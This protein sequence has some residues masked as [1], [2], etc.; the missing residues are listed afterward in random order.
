MSALAR[1]AGNAGSLSAAL[2]S[3]L[4]VGALGHHGAVVP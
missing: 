3:A 1:A 2:A 4:P